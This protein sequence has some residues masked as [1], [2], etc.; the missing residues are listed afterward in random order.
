MEQCLGLCKKPYTKVEN[1]RFTY[2]YM[3]RAFVPAIIFHDKDECPDF[4]EDE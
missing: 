3:Q 1:L 2:I 4:K